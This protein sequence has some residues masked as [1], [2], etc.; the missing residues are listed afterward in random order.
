MPAVWRERSERLQAEWR[1]RGGLGADMGECQ[2]K[3]GMIHSLGMQ[4]RAYLFSLQIKLD[5]FHGPVHQKQKVQDLILMD[6]SPPLD[7]NLQGLIHVD[8][9]VEQVRPLGSLGWT[10][11]LIP[12][13]LSSVRHHS[14]NVPYHPF[15]IIH[16]PPSSD[17]HRPLS[18]PHDPSSVPHHLPSVPHHL[19]SVPHH[20]YQV[21]HHHLSSAAISCRKALLAQCP[22]GQNSPSK[23]GHDGSDIHPGCKRSWNLQP[24]SEV[25]GVRL[26][27]SSTPTN[28]WG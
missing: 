28:L 15:S 5:L 26:L 16:P 14:S 27:T 4:G 10:L 2:G 17:P 18:V 3:A 9:L 22:T 13:H 23:R 6:P 20:P 7:E 24:L 25:A 1:R 11:E 8:N 12:H 21:S 19:L